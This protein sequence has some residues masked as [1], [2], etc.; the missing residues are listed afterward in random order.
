MLSDWLNRRNEEAERR[1]ELYLTLSSSYGSYG[2]DIMRATKLRAGR[3]Y[4]ALD[5]LMAADRIYAFWEP[6]PTGKHRRRM[7]GNHPRVFDASEVMQ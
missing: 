1:I 5:R 2:L 6:N 4:P 3:M 7:Y